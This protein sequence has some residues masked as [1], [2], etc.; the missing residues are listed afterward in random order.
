MKRIFSAI[1]IL[2]TLISCTLSV[3][4]LSPSV[5]E[6]ELDTESDL[7]KKSVVFVGD[8]ISEAR[9]E[10]GKDAVGWAG[11]IINWN[12]MRGLN[13][14]KSGASVSD[15]RGENTVI[16]QLKAITGKNSYD[17]V[18]MHGGVNDAWDE[19]PVGVMTN[20]FDEAFDTTTF[21]GGLEA[22]FKYAKENFKKAHFGFII[23][24]SLPSAKYGKLSDMSEYFTVAKQICEKWEISYLDLY[25]DDN[26]N[27]NIMQT[28]SM[29]YLGDFIHPNP[30][31]YDVLAPY[32]NAWMKTIKAE[33]EKQESSEAAEQT[34]AEQSEAVSSPESSE[35]GD[36]AEM[37]IYIVCGII[38]LA[39]VAYI[40]VALKKKK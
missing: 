9:N 3:G 10:W 20:G 5:P 28:K 16:N 11:R 40:V 38:A 39:A 19:A 12:K 4:A 36:K 18:I 1:L 32:I 35:K 8:S 27:N 25:F 2:L 24:F 21:A 23:N 15:C 7:Y 14:S 22:T 29:K 30:A 31:G 6:E 34:T 13:K 37:I 33:S 17:Y 26:F